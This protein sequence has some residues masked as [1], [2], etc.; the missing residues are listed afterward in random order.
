MKEVK[1]TAFKKYGKYFSEDIVEIPENIE[2]WNITSYL[3]END[4]LLY[5]DMFNVIKSTADVKKLDSGW[6][7]PRLYLPERKETYLKEYTKI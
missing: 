4:L 1:I 3:L 6:F 7:P 2:S 5:P